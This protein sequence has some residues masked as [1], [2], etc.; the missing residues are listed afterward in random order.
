MYYVF[1][2][3]FICILICFSGSYR[4]GA[5]SCGDVDIL[6]T[7]PDGRSHRNLLEPLLEK[8][9]G[10]LLHHCWWRFWCVHSEGISDRWFDPFNTTSN[11]YG[12]LLSCGMR[13]IYLSI[14]FFLWYQFI[15]LLSA[16]LFPIYLVC[17]LMHPSNVS[18]YL[19]V[20]SYVYRE[21]CIE[22]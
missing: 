1:F 16:I 22:G 15:C 19:F 21:V 7:H 18:I 9:H 4:R 5:T 6:I 14:R 12:H 17:L 10:M 20:Y 2:E 8:L 3:Q 13:C 11:I